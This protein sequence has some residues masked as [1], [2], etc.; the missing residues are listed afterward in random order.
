MIG[1][2]AALL[3]E[4]LHDLLVEK[5][6]GPVVHDPADEL[7]GTCLPLRD[8][9]ESKIHVQDFNRLVQG[10]LQL[11]LD[12]KGRHDSI[13]DP[14]D[15]IQLLV[16]VEEAGGQALQLLVEQVQILATR[17]HVAPHPAGLRSGS[18]G[19]AD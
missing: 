18:E 16:T 19:D 8:H 5:T 11:L 14:V 15:E 9:Y 3:H 10:Q 12:V 6:Q 4:G 13:R 2:R 7:R 17:C 1:P